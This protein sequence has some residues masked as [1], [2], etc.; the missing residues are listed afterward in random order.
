MRI[1][2]IFLSK[3]KWMTGYPYPEFDNEQFGNN[4]LE[5][6]KNRFTDIEFAGGD[7]ITS[8]IPKKIEK[9]KKQIKKS[10]GFLLCTIGLFQGFP[11]L[12]KAGN[13]FLDI[14]LP[15]ILLNYI[16]GG[17]YIFILLSEYA[18]R[19]NLPVVSVSTTEHIKAEKVISI[20]TGLIRLKNE[21]IINITLD[22]PKPSLSNED[23][24]RLMDLFKPGLAKMPDEVKQKLLK[25]IEGG[26]CY[27]DVEGIDQCHQWR[28]NEARYKNNLRNIFGVEMVRV[29]PDELI[30]LYKIVDKKDYEKVSENWIKNAQTIEVN[31]ETIN[32]SARLYIAI[33]TLMRSMNADAI[34]L[35]CATLTM[36]GK[37][38]ALPCMPFSQLN[39]EGFIGACESDMDCAI[40]MLLGRNIIRRPGFIANN[41]YD[42]SNNR[43]TYLHCTAPFKPY[44]QEE[45]SDYDIVTNADARYI[46]VSP[47]VHYPIGEDFTT[48][49]ISI[50]EKKIAICSGKTLGSVRNK[51]HAGIKFLSRPTQKK[52]LKTIMK[53]HLAGIGLIFWVILEMIF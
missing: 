6:L 10:D 11:P 3:P 32:N 38:Y 34:T 50:L 12:I 25:M 37:L 39:S 41:T 52:Y 9:L 45:Y 5:K 46:G 30:K 15:T 27:V 40:T 22:E 23:L 24:T 28:R 20:L 2:C 48:I 4:I 33:K 42:L 8:Y 35:D 1:H 7:I 18:R 17:D 49:K 44:N 21:H 36:A 19:K 16:Y 51:K 53:K 29:H 47:L 31:C 14:G 13:E 43:I 26:E